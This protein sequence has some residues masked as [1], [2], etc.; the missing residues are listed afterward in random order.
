MKEYL[1]RHT[2]EEMVKFSESEDYMVRQWVAGQ[3]GLPAYLYE[4]LA[5]DEEPYVRGFL[6]AN[7]DAPIHVLRM[8]LNDEDEFVLF[9]LAS[10]ESLT[11]GDLHALQRKHNALIDMALIQ[12]PATSAATLVNILPLTVLK[13]RVMSIQEVIFYE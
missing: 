12:N 1:H 9:G 11:T 5:Q 6:A 7:E 8:L 4:F 10:N 3:K 2:E 13:G